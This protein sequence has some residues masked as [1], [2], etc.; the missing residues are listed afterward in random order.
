[1]TSSIGLLPAVVENQR[2]YESS[3]SPT[4]LASSI[5]EVSTVD[6]DA[7]FTKKHGRTYFGYKLHIGVDDAGWIL[8]SKMT[9]GYEQDP[10][11]VPELLS[12]YA[13]RIETVVADGIYDRADVYEA[14]QTH[15]PDAIIVIPPRKDAVTSGSADDPLLSLSVPNTH[16]TLGR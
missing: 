16:A 10:G 9:D 8:A 1:M 14:I 4:L 7:G 2:E 6:P 5:G 3:T 15:S 11:Q 12:Q 13:G